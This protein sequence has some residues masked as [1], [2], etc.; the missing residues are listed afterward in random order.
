MTQQRPH[1]QEAGEPSIP[2]ERTQARQ[3]RVPNPLTPLPPGIELP[4]NANPD[5]LLDIDEVAAYLKVHRRTVQNLIHDKKLIG[6]R[7][8]RFWRITLADLRA[9]ID[10]QRQ[11]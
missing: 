5:Q 1:S 9:F 8:L 10:K 4:E 11:T 3:R 7:I 6:T 2:T